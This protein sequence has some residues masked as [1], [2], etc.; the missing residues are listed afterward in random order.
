MVTLLVW[1]PSGSGTQT[2]M[3]VYFSDMISI[4]PAVPPVPKP[5][6]PPWWSP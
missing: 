3:E 1:D 2:L 6:Q 4:S 5:P